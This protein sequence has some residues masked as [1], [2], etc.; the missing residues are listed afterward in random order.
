MPT[1]TSTTEETKE[2]EVLKSETPDI[3]K[4][5]VPKVVDNSAQEAEARTRRLKALGYV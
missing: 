3:K 1:F 2:T 5:E 4:P